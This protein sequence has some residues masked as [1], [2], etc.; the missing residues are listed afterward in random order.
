MK[1]LFLLRHA[2]SS[3]SD[4]SLD[5]FDRTLNPRGRQACG[6]VAAYIASHRMAPDLVLCSA[7]Q[8]VR[9][10]V[11]GLVGAFDAPPQIVFEESLYMAAAD[12]LLARLHAVPDDVGTVMMVGHNPGLEDLAGALVGGGDPAAAARM[13]EKYPTA[14]LAVFTLTADRWRDVGR[15]GAT[16]DAFVRP[17]DLTD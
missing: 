11:D 15:Q 7:A 16:L 1:S 4:P 8:R 13:M 9:E 6:L 3:W 12:R 2:K 17:R 5:D 10:T 14:A